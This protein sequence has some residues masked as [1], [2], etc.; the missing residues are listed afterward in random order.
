M[1]GSCDDAGVGREQGDQGFWCRGGGSI[2][3][4]VDFPGIE[5]G[6]AGQWF[7]CLCGYR[8]ERMAVPASWGSWVEHAGRVSSQFGR[9]PVRQGQRDWES[10]R[11]RC[12]SP[13]TPDGC[14][15]QDS[16]PQGAIGSDAGVAGAGYAGIVGL[17]ATGLRASRP[18]APTV[19]RFI[20]TW[21]QPWLTS[22]MGGMEYSMDKGKK[23]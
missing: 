10:R 23:S 7:G 16:E 22:F 1:P 18:Q 4:P 15:G 21:L 14:P 6:H 17:M 9:M 20:H 11:R 5:R 13:G 19:T 12:V 3:T 2:G 8:A